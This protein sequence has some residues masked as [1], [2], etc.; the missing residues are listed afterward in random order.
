ML[1][2]PDMACPDGKA[3][4]LQIGSQLHFS[5]DDYV[6]TRCLNSRTFPVTTHW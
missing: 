2:F 6:V 3:L 4:D 5:H 1:A